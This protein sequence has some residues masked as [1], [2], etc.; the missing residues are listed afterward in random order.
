MPERDQRIDANRAPRRNITSEQGDTEEKK[1]DTS[2]RQRIRGAHAVKETRHQVG[3]D[4]GTNESNRGARQGE[5]E[6]LTQNH[7]EDVPAL[8][9]ECE[10][11][12][13]LVSAFA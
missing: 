11:N 10:A 13:D 12:A 8:R 7:L 2:K 6:S 3:H 5:A 4:Q 9:P 1:S